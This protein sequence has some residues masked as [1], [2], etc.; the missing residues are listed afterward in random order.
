MARVQSPTT[1][2]AEGSGLN[3]GTSR[4]ESEV[5]YVNKNK[6]EHEFIMHYGARVFA[7]TAMAWV[8]ETAFITPPAN[9]ALKTW[10]CTSCGEQGYEVAQERV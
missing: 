5:G 6:H 7:D 3:P 2:T 4:F 8:P 9:A 10:R 1:P